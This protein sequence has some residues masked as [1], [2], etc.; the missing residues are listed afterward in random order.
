MYFD[1]YTPRWHSDVVRLADKVFGEGY[2]VRPSEIAAEPGSVIFIGQ[3]KDEM[4]LG[5]AQ[6]R[7]LPQ[8]GLQDH[9]GGHV[10]DISSE[11]IDA[12]EEGA[13]GVIQAIAVAPECRRCGYGTKLVAL[14]HDRLIGLGADKMI[15]TFK[16]GPSAP[17]VD[18][19]MG[20][21][22]FE[23]WQRLPSNW[24]ER[25]DAGDFRWI[26]RQNSCTCEALLYRKTIY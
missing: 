23:I 14:L 24:Q 5:F 13:L 19:M 17:H 22:G 12:D 26:D 3:E 15:V 8:G 1:L 21:L 4:L 16:R 18:G 2:F 11:I 25:C 7:V 10:A 6:G 9:M 20:K